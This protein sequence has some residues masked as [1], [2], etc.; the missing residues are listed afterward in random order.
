MSDAYHDNLHAGVSSKAFPTS[1]HP[2]GAYVE[3]LVDGS[4]IVGL[5]YGCVA[6]DNYILAALPRVFVKGTT[7]LR[8]TCGQTFTYRL[9]G[10]NTSSEYTVSRQA[11]LCMQ[12]ASCNIVHLIKI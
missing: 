12:E 9:T 3:P 8:N 11:K 5:I 6:W 7:V 4:R 1:L 2:H 10:S